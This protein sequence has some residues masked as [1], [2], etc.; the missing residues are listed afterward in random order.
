MVYNYLRSLPET[1]L[2]NVYASDE[3]DWDRYEKTFTFP[4]EYEFFKY[5]N[6]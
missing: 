6:T 3:D 1:A 4:T 2:G 5:E